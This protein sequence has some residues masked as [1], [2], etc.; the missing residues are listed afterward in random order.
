[1][2]AAVL[3]AYPAAFESG[4]IEIALRSCLNEAF[5]VKRI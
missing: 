2:D 4:R 3:L 1:M 5:R